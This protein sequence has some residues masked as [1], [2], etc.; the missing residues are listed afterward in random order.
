MMINEVAGL[1][2]YAFVQ[3]FSSRKEKLFTC[4]PLIAS[5]TGPSKERLR[6]LPETIENVCLPSGE[7]QQQS[8]QEES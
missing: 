1:V 6:A 5:L 2:P 3:R 7:S 4:A 8:Q